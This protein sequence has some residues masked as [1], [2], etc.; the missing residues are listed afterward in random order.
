M[1]YRIDDKML[2]ASIFLR[3]DYRAA[4]T[5]GISEAGDW[6]PASSTCQGEHP[7]HAVFRFTAGN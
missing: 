7:Y 1:E 4:Y 2:K 3:N 6:K 5:S